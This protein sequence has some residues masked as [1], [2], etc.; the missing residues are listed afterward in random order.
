MAK[1]LD[2]RRPGRGQTD[3]DLDLAG[4]VSGRGLWSH[5]KSRHEYLLTFNQSFDVVLAG[6]GIPAGSV[7]GKR[8]TVSVFP[9]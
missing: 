6:P 8:K 4:F 2:P 1:K 3:C 7:T 5:E 9:V